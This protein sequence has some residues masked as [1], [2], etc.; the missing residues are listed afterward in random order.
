VTAADLQEAVDLERWL[1]H[2]ERRVAVA[3]AHRRERDPAPD[4]PFRGLY[5][6]DETVDR[7]LGGAAPLATP[8]PAPALDDAPL[9]PVVASSVLPAREGT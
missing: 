2:V 6:N 5:V 9:N 1:L 4:D 7:L 3:V 8:A